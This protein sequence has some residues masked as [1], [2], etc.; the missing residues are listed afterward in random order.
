M[1]FM[2][3]FKNLGNIKEQ[4]EQIQQRMA[5]IQVTGEAGAGMV[6]VT[7]SGDGKVTN[8]HIDPGLVGP[9]GKDMLEELIISAT[10]EA[11]KKTKEAMAHEMKTLTGGMNIPGMEK[12]FGG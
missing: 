1:N 8:I 6:Q 10:N 9:D 7:M 3:L 4:M 11:L 12:F 2:D 5:K